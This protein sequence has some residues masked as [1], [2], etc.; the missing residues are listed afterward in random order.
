MKSGIRNR[1]SANKFKFA[2]MLR[3]HMTQAERLLWDEIKKKKLCGYRFRRQSII[4]GWIVDFYCPAKKLVIEVDGSSHRHK[5]KQDEYRDKV[6]EE[7]GFKVVRF[8]NDEVK[9]QISSVLLRIANHA[10]Q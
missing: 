2:A 7:R 3:K 4:Y 1:V 5:A 8:T 9:E 6:M 10:N